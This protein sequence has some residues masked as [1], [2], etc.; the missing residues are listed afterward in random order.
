MEAE[1][2]SRLKSSEELGE[3]AKDFVAR[4]EELIHEIEK[5]KA[6]LR[7]MN[8]KMVDVQGGICD[9][10]TFICFY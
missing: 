6:Q 8:K 5:H 1:Q 9:N 7:D 2:S 10:S 4:E 3:K